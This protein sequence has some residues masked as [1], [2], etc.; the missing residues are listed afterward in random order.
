MVVVRLRVL[1]GLVG[2]IV[3]LVARGGAVCAR[4]AREVQST[5]E[6]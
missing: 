5:W 2:A 4:S 1:V 6:R 3:E